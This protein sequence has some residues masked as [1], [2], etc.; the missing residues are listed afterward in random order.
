MLVRAACRWVGVPWRARGTATYFWIIT[1]TSLVQAGASA[2]LGNAILRASSTNLNGLARNPV[3]VLIT[4]ALWLDKG[5]YLFFAATAVLVLAPLERW[6]GWW[7]WLVAFAL[8]HVGASLLVAVG[9]SVGVHTGRISPS[10]SRVIDV[11][12]SYGTATCAALLCYLAPRRWRWLAAA[13]LWAVVLAAL[14]E[15]ANPTAWGH[16]AAAAI[17]FACYP[18][19]LVRRRPSGSPLDEVD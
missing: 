2:R 17:G 10:I 6:L 4:S 7:R 3:N 14:V 11:G 9:L 15:D 19:T 1:A 18:L 12:A 16:A 13:G 5:G 8:G